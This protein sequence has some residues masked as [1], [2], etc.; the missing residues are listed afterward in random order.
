MSYQEGFKAFYRN[1]PQPQQRSQKSAQ[2]TAVAKGKSVA[3]ESERVTSKQRADELV[4]IAL[5]VRTDYSGVSR[6][7]S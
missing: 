6:Y 5:S 4:A 7:V 2:D 1:R 3:P